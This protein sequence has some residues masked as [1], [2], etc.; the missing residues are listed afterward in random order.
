MMEGRKGVLMMLGW[1][2]A[3]LLSSAGWPGK[4]PQGTGNSVFSYS[5]RTTSTS[6][7]T[8]KTSACHPPCHPARGCSQL[9]KPSIAH[10]PMTGRGTGRE[11]GHQP[12]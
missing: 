1:V 12:G 10:P 11:A 6:L 5:W 4:T 9:W 3:L 2:P 7:W 8:P